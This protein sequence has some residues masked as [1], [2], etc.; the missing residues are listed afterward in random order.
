[1]LLK[2]FSY[3]S[4]KPSLRNL[5][6][7]DKWHKHPRYTLNLIYNRQKSMLNI[8]SSSLKVIFWEQI[9]NIGVHSLALL[10]LLGLFGLIPTLFILCSNVDQLDSGFLLLF[11][12]LMIMS[13]ENKL[14]SSL[15]LDDPAEA[16]LWLLNSC[17]VKN[18]AEDHFRNSIKYKKKPPN[19]HTLLFEAFCVGCCWSSL[20][21]QTKSKAK[22]TLQ[23]SYL[24]E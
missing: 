22:Q 6:V 3:C 14:I 20:M 12:M 7:R 21:Q 4:L 13:C 15:S 17:T 24:N 8:F 5:L 1:M 23:S 10:F 18:P 11:V 2:S 9:S 19:T 16:D